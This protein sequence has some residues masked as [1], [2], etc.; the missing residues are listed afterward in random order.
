[1]SEFAVGDKVFVKP[2]YADGYLDRIQSKIKD[3]RVGE[4]FSVVSAQHI[5][6]YFHKD[7]RKKEFRHH[8]RS[9]YLEKA[10]P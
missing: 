10:A 9:L 5:V 7:G 4:I 8:F 6:V 1:M 2:E 3:C